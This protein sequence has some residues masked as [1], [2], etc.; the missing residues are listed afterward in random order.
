MPSAPV[1]LHTSPAPGTTGTP[2]A[3][4]GPHLEASSEPSV[5]MTSTSFKPGSHWLPLLPSPV[6]TGVLV[7]T[8]SQ[9]TVTW[10]LSLPH[11]PAQFQAR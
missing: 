5:E 3:P 9:K 1:S 11:H 8:P 10:S 6:D 2:S 4:S 7:L